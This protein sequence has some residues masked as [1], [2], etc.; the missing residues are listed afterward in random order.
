VD[1]QFIISKIFTGIW[2]LLK[3]TSCILYGEES[4]LRNVAC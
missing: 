3:P 1:K 2:I 4:S